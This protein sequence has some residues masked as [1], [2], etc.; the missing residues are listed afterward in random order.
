MNKGCIKY[1]IFL[2]P[3]I[4]SINLYSQEVKKV[5]LNKADRL[6]GKKTDGESLNILI[7]N[8]E[9]QH[10]SSLFFCDSAVMIKLN[11]SFRAYHEVYIMVN[12]SVDIY[13]DSLHYNGN[14][15]IAEIYGNVKLIEKKAILYTDHL[16]FNRNTKIAYY[17][18]WG[19]IIDTTNEL[20]SKIGYYYSENRDFFFRKNV[21]LTNPDYI[22]KSDS[23][24]YNTISE[25]ASFYGPTTIVGEEDSVY[26]EYGWYNT[27]NDI[28]YLTLNSFVKHLE[29]SISGD[30]L[31][32]EKNRD[33]GWGLNNITISDT[34]QDV[35]AKANKAL[36]NKDEGFTRITDS[37]LAIFIDGLDS[38][39]L[40][41]DTLIIL[42]DS[43]DQAERII[44]WNHVKFFRDDLQG[45]SDSLVY[46]VNDSSVNMY[47]NP[48]IWSDE[49]QL[50][51]DSIK[52]V[53]ADNKI[54][55]VAFYNSCFIIARDDTNSY[56]Q[57]KGKNM[58]GYFK[59][60]QLYKLT[61]FGN[62]ETILLCKR[63]RWRTYW[64]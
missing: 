34:L 58:V 25:T 28:V 50:T 24:K 14:T 43:A 46:V 6:V 42:F 36:Y 51:A 45:A 18:T 53:I 26:S 59:R 44:A 3:F 61:V 29:Q 15:Q 37:T 49:N 30:T 19:R 17:Q 47:V 33:Y 64:N 54:D 63:R 31:Y 16:T 5:K 2:I 60:N 23:L 55:T 9:L 38:L 13:G 21:I 11:N 41:A 62:S 39:Y 52:M 20:R 32:Y 48:V 56:N 27:Q 57:I 40:H 8:V 22:L 10:D 4:L 7:G 12:D 1:L 35:I